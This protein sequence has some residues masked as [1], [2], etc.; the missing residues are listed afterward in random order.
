MEVRGQQSTAPLALSGSPGMGWAVARSQAE[1]GFPNPVPGAWRVSPGDEHTLEKH[2]QKYTPPPAGNFPLLKIAALPFNS[3]EY[4]S[5]RGSHSEG[6]R[7]ELV[8]AYAKTQTLDTRDACLVDVKSLQF[9]F[10]STYMGL[11]G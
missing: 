10:L 8:G 3:H 1:S 7:G 9:S 2:Q 6:D 4:S 5:V 11:V